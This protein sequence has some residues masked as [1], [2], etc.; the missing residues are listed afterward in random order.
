MSRRVT[1]IM[2][3]LGFLALVPAPACTARS[4]GGPSSAVARAPR[5]PERPGSGAAARPASDEELARYAAREKSSSG[6]DRFEG[7]RTDVTT[8][9]I[10]LLL[11]IVIILLV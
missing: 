9:I 8:I 3:L 1:R 7:G 4:V 10:V 2:V 5:A 11:V 6:L